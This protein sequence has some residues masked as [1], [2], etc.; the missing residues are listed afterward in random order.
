M[1]IILFILCIIPNVISFSALGKKASLVKS[2]V[3]SAAFFFILFILTSSVYFLFDNFR[4]KCVL[5]TCFAIESAVAAILVFVFKKKIEFDYSIKNAIIPTAVVALLTPFLI[6][7]FG[8]FGMGQDQGVYQVKAL[9]LMNGVTQYQTD[10]DEYSKLDSTYEKNEF[11]S[12]VKRYLAGYDRHQ[13][14]FPKTTYND[15][16]SP[17]SGIFHGI[18]VYPA[19]L[20]LWGFMFGAENMA[21]LSAFWLIISIYLISFCCDNLK[22]KAS[23]KLMVCSI[24]GF[25]PI[26]IWVSKSTL[27]EMFIS[28]LLL[29]FTYLITRSEYKW[30]SV[31][32][33]VAYAFYHVS[34]FTMLPMFIIIYA[35]LYIFTNDRKFVVCAAVSC[36]SY[37]AGFFTM[38]ALQPIYTLNNYKVVYNSLINNKNVNIVIYIL[39][40]ICIIALAVFYMI[41]NKIRKNSFLPEQFISKVFNGKTEKI[42]IPIAIILP[43]VAIGFKMYGD[44][45]R[46]TF[47]TIMSF[48]YLTGMIIIPLSLIFCAVK[49]KVIVNS[50]NTL[51]VFALFEYCV[52]IYSWVLRPDIQYY[53]YYSRYISSFIP[54]AL[55]F[56][57]IVLNSINK[58]YITFPVIVGSLCFILPYDNLLAQKKDDTI[59]QWNVLNDVIDSANEGDCYIVDDIYASTCWF[60]LKNISKADV[61]PVIGDVNDQLS[62]MKSKY[63]NVYYLTDMPVTYDK[64]PLYRVIYKNK[65]YSSLD[66]N[67][68]KGK[69]LP[70]P[71]DFLKFEDG[72]YIYKYNGY[73]LNYTADECIDDFYGFSYLE[74]DS[75]CWITSKESAVV[76]CLKPDNYVM[77]VE[78]GA[79]IPFEDLTFT[80]E[81]NVSAY[82]NGILV[83]T[84]KINKDNADKPLVFKIDRN[85]MLN[86]Q[87]TVSFKSD[88]WSPSEFGSEDERQLGFSISSINFAEAK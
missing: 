31:I 30:L 58:K 73:K 3:L 9:N 12:Q 70:L 39:M 86:M 34:F 80:K 55:I 33:V 4:M 75:F 18:P 62:K 13:P 74:Q 37:A 71:T 20:A 6:T 83:G 14:D 2:V 26:M 56:G 43:L 64:E 47:S 87:N 67:C 53:Y 44:Y 21:G 60:P 48:M 11:E 81:I 69:V 50:V 65:V 24:M 63:K 59:M 22:I 23:V 42:L 72:I 16:I 19:M 35:A 10:F 49:P 85:I 52:L 76:T 45:E 15:N 79:Q 46:F 88:L 78:Q 68:T 29:S 57:G 5:A 77:T 40:A 61:Y 17:V 32:P 38:R 27:T 82:V 84:V 66:D 1:F 25:S 41:I 36:L 7:H 54:V 51:T 8:Y 28:V